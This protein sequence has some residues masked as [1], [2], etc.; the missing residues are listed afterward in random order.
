MQ[1]H[2]KFS[3]L[4][5]PQNSTA[6]EWDST[7]E[8]YSTKKNI[9]SVDLRHH[10]PSRRVAEPHLVLPDNK[11]DDF[12]WTWYNDCL[13]QEHVLQKFQT[14]GFTGFQPRPVHLH[15]DPPSNLPLPKL[16]KLELTGWGG[17]AR[18]ESGIRLR[19][20][21]PACGRQV[22]TDFDRPELLI[23]EIQW[24]GSDFF[25][26]WPM[27]L[28]VFIT[29]RVSRFVRKNRLTGA[30]ILDTGEMVASAGSGFGPGRLS[31]WMP[32]ERARQLCEPLGIR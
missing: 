4:S 7:E 32:E 30:K 5:F 29:D 12:V 2:C 13:V 28:F 18:P 11:L 14:E 20:Y 25:M 22:Y 10:V 17:M 1:T 21:C 6:L 15:R 16:W 8:F 24:D 3:L 26:V 19:E 9:C 31:L 23:D 27:P